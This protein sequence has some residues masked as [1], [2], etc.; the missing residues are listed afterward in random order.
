MLLL[1]CFYFFLQ[2][3]AADT[4]TQQYDSE[5]KK[6][7][8]LCSKRMME[9]FDKDDVWDCCVKAGDLLQKNV[10]DLHEEV[11]ACYSVIWIK[12]GVFSAFGHI[13][14]KAL[15]MLDVCNEVEGAISLRSPS[16][17]PQEPY[18]DLQT[19]VEDLRKAYDD[20]RGGELSQLTHM[21]CNQALCYKE[22]IKDSVCVW[23]AMLQHAMYL[24]YA[25]LDTQNVSQSYLD[26]LR[27]LMPSLIFPMFEEFQQI[28]ENP[29][30]RVLGVSVKTVNDR[31]VLEETFIHFLHLKLESF[32]GCCPD[33]SYFTLN[34]ARIRA[35]LFRAVCFAAHN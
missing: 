14:A 1:F 12:Y 21:L 22:N 5:S 29:I 4:F 16:F 25:P 9:R 34:L 20:K 23:K 15:N 18:S 7:L 17:E 33:P 2:A 35:L 26:A 10:T 30:L 24:R 11:A 27:P 28:T 8:W 32:K 31:T 3:D 19:F 6:K 13:K